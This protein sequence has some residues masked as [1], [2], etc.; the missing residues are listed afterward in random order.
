[1]ASSAQKPRDGDRRVILTPIAMI[2]LSAGGGGRGA[3]TR[4][5]AGIVEECSEEGGWG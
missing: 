4:K 2:I 1:M 5:K 3:F